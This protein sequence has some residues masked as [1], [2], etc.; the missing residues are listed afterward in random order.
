[1][2]PSN[3]ALAVAIEPDSIVGRRSSL[4]L[5]ALGLGEHAKHMKHAAH[6]WCRGVE[7]FL[8]RELIDPLAVQS[9]RNS[10]RS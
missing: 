3:R 1:M 6:G 10:S 5:G 7:P 8:T 2:L 4:L 9:L